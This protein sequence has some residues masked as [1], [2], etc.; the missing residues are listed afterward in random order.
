M[1]ANEKK[2]IAIGAGVAVAAALVLAMRARAIDPGKGVLMGKV[3]DIDSGS[4]INNINVDCN[5]YTGKTNAHGN[6]EIINIEPGWY[7]VIFTDPHG[8]YE[9]EVV[10]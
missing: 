4:P 5:G 3:T 2:G 1:A 7:D 10:S 9:T 6:Y 8:R